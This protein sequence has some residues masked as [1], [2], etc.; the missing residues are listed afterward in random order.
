MQGVGRK[1][2]VHPAAAVDGGRAVC[3][4]CRRELPLDEKGLPVLETGFPCS[5]SLPAPF[6]DEVAVSV[7]DCRAMVVVNGSIVD[8]G[9]I[10]ERHAAELKRLAEESVHRAGGA[11]NWSGVYPPSEELCEYV[12]ELRRRGFI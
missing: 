7:W 1:F 9:K 8:Y 2:Y 12:A 3:V 11:L 4:Y 10:P 5:V 6:D